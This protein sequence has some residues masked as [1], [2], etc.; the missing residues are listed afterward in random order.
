VCV[1]SGHLKYLTWVQYHVFKLFLWTTKRCFVNFF[2]YINTTWLGSSSLWK[3]WI[4]VHKKL[5]FLF[6]SVIKKSRYNIRNKR[7]LNINRRY[8]KNVEGKST[9]S[10][11]ISLNFVQEKFRKGVWGLS[12]EPDISGG[13]V[14]HRL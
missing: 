3:Y 2:F 7:C 9:W 10:N 6:G 11:T 4:F 12:L 8:K 1:S 5:I 13:L 14:S